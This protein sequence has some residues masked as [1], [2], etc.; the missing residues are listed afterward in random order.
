[1]YTTCNCCMLHS[2]HSTLTSTTSN[3][4]QLND[5]FQRRNVCIFNKYATAQFIEDSSTC[6]MRALCMVEMNERYM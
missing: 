4:L 3:L 6:L 1:M 2:A 5:K